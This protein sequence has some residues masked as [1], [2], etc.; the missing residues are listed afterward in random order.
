M[1]LVTAVV[2]WQGLAACLRAKV[3]ASTFWWGTRDAL[4][5][6]VHGGVYHDGKTSLKLHMILVII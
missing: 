4:Q 6:L 5:W 2:D 1:W 3:R